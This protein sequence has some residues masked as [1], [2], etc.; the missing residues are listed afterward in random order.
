VM[1]KQYDI[2]TMKTKYRWDVR[3]GVT[4]LQPEMAGLMLFSQT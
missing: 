4:M 1:Q 3:F 2:N